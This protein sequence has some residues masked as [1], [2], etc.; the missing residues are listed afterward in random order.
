VQEEATCRAEDLLEGCEGCQGKTIGDAK[1]TRDKAVAEAKTTKK[2]AGVEAY[3]AKEKAE[4]EEPLA[5]FLT[6][7]A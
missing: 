2:A 1:A 4:T 6:K 5:K 7:M 3:A